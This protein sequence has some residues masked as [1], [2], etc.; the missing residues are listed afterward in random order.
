[1]DK[2]YEALSNIRHNGV[3]YEAGQVIGDLDEDSAKTLLEANV[4]VA[5]EG[6]GGEKAAATTPTG[7]QPDGFPVR[8]VPPAQP[9][10]Q[11]QP[12][13]SQP[14]APT[15]EQLVANAA[16]KGQPTPEEVAATANQVA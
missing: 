3:T 14:D 7:P 8:D 4:I 6:K 5:K 12:A 1:M 2:T 16:A 10:A 13:P 15:P 11:S 9:Q